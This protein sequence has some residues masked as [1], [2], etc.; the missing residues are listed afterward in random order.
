[1][2]LSELYRKAIST[3]IDNDPRGKEAV[4]K[5]LERLRKKFDDL[6][7]GEKEIFDAESLENPYADSRILVGDGEED[8]S[9]IMVGIDIDVGEIL[10]ADALRQRNTMIDL[11]ISHHPGGGAFG[12]LF[13]VLSMQSE[14]LRHFGVPINVAEALMEGR[15]KEVERR[16]MPANHARSEDAARLLGFPFMCL[17]TP[18][19][20]MVAKYLQVIFDSRQPY[21]LDDVI[22]ML[23]E[24]PEFKAAGKYNAGPDILIG[25]G[26]RQAGKIFVD[27]TGGTEGAKEIYKSLNTAG[28]NTIVGMHMSEDH[29]KEAESHHINVI[30]AGHIAADNLGMNLLLDNVIGTDKINVIECSGFRRNHRT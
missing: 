7:S 18:A 12:N 1:M 14:I 6:K 28:V 19:D 15:S 11:L 8:I 22:D 21:C 23:R 10:L 4:I 13:A 29:R 9:N 24:I 3:G 2:K 30:I 17:H 5:K 20:N 25:S 26:K 16:L 27:M